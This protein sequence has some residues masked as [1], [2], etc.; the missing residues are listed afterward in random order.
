[1]HDSDQKIVN[2]GVPQGSNLRSLLF[3]L[4]INKTNY[5]GAQY[6]SYSNKIYQRKSGQGYIEW[7]LLNT[8][9]KFLGVIIDNNFT[10]QNHTNT[11]KHIIHC[12]LILPYIN[13]DILIQVNSSKIYLNKIFY[14]Q[15]WAIKTISNS[16]CRTNDG[17]LSSTY[18]FTLMNMINLTAH[19]WQN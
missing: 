4:Y 6:S 18:G 15:I 14:I 9:L 10:Q 17:L 11:W 5:N 2:S 12:T 19:N 7:F 1:M 8:I 16:Y 3:I 13:C